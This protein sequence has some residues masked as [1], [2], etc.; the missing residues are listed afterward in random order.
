MSKPPKNRF[1]E[2]MRAVMHNMG[3]SL[4]EVAQRLNT[5]RQ[6]S[7]EISFR[8][9]RGM[10]RRYRLAHDIAVIIREPESKVRWFIGLNPWANS[11]SMNDLAFLW[12]FCERLVRIKQSGSPKPD[13]GIYRTLLRQMFGGASLQDEDAVLEM[14][15]QHSKEDDNA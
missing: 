10:D 7:Y 14:L 15:K 3:T 2:Y 9:N 1:H 8:P 6:F 5:I 13:L 11:L 12:E 4:T